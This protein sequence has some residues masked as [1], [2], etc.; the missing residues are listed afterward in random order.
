MSRGHSNLPKAPAIDPALVFKGGIVIAV[1]V[2]I[3]LI[4]VGVK[5]LVN[6]GTSA[7]AG[8]AAA[9]AAAAVQPVA[10]DTMTFVATA[11]VR[12]KVARQ[13]DG[14]ELFQT[15]LAQ[16]ERRD[17]PNVPLYLTANALES[18]Q[19]EYKGKLYNIGARGYQKVKISAFAE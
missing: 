18:V 7:D 8:R 14:A 13:S 12:I 11:P 3:L 4:V 9:V 16:G 10:G 17:A 5:S 19:I 6:G 2:V 1:G 15:T